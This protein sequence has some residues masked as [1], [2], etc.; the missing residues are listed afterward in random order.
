MQNNKGIVSTK[1]KSIVTSRRQEGTSNQANKDTQELLVFIILIF[2][3][4]ECIKNVILIFFKEGW[5]D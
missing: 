1:F 5:N 3:S 4:Y 2:I